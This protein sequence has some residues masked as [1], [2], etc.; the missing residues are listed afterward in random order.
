MPTVDLYAGFNQWYLSE[1]VK[2]LTAFTIPGLAAE[3]G[4]LQFRVL[5]FG[6][7]SAPTRLNSLVA[8]TS[9]E[10]RFGNHEATKETACCTNYI[11]DVFIANICS[12]EEQAT[13]IHYTTPPPPPP[14]PFASTLFALPRA[15]KQNHLLTPLI[16]Y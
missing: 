8:S 2:P 9:K 6:L 7:A 16:T 10:P 3:E 13:L 5:P 12:F 15:S 1:E 14:L 4:R 11:D